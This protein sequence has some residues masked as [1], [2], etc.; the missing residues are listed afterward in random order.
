M[1]NWLFNDILCMYYL[2]IWSIVIGV[3]TTAITVALSV[4]SESGKHGS[5]N[6]KCRKQNRENNYKKLLV[7]WKG[8]SKMTI[9]FATLMV[10]IGIPGRDSKMCG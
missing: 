9:V 5:K 1:R 10:S 6:K 4:K 7:E 2:P 8:V 3:L